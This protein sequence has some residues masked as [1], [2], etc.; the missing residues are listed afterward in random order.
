VPPPYPSPASGGGDA[1][2]DAAP[3]RQERQADGS[4]SAWCL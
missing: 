3:L 4:A 2:G 1:G